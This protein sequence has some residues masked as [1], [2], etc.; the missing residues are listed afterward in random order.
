[1][2]DL[3]QI[4]S[5][6]AFLHQTLHRALIPL[7]QLG[8]LVKIKYSLTQPKLSFSTL[9]INHLFHITGC[10]RNALQSESIIANIS[11]VTGLKTRLV[12]RLK[13]ACMSKIGVNY[14]SRFIIQAVCQ[15]LKLVLCTRAAGSWKKVQT[16]RPDEANAGQ[17][18]LNCM[19]RQQP[20]SETPG[21]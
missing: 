13:L 8:F 9:S 14:I 5:L 2:V 16:Y 20:M 6:G 11:N 4:S 19:V 12:Y 10:K 1:M 15:V 17:G 3:L 21:Q 7:R 18:T